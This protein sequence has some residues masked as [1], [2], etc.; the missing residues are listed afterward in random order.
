MTTWCVENENPA[1][2]AHEGGDWSALVRR[3]AT[4]VAARN[5][6]P[7]SDIDLLARI[8]CEYYEMPGMQ[9]TLAQASRL[10][11]LDV[12]T[13]SRLLDVLVDASFLR[14][15]GPYYLRSESGRLSA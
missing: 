13:T 11:D 14:R 4:N 10:W 5:A 12:E 15:V 7:G 1:N 3:R 6:T 9:L 2:A 8:C